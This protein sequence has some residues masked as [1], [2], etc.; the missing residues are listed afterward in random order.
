[1][2]ERRTAP[3]TAR[4]IL[5]LVQGDRIIMALEGEIAARSGHKESIA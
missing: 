3:T 1:M 2:A 4:Q 5:A